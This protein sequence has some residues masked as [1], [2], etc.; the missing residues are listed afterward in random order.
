[1]SQS[2]HPIFQNLF[3]FHADVFGSLRPDEHNKQLYGHILDVT[4]Q[5]AL[6]SR[7]IFGMVYVYNRL[8]QYVVDRKTV[9]LFQRD[10][11]LMARTACEEGNPN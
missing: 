5:H 3:P 1:M 2:S 8:P 10:L 4:F 7:S 9:S 11:T 6:H